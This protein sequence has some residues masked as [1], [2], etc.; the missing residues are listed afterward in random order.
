MIMMSRSTWWELAY[1]SKILIRTINL[2][3]RGDWKLIRFCSLD[4][5]ARWASA[6]L[7]ILL[8][9]WLFHSTEYTWLYFYHLSICLSPFYCI[10][11]A[12]IST[13]LSHVLYDSHKINFSRFLW[14]K[15]FFVVQQR[16]LC[17]RIGHA[18]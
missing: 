1:F 7:T 4:L 13:N 18:V 15:A 14:I 3:G 11:R 17:W 5:S 8:C 6:V 12:T 16:S 2:F 10:L 9:F